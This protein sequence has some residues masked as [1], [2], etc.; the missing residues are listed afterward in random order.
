VNEA[1]PQEFIEQEALAQQQ[2]EATQSK[3]EAFEE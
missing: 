2:V 3:L 1:V